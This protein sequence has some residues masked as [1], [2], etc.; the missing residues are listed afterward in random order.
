[1]CESTLYIETKDDREKIADD[2]AL[3]LFDNGEI[4]VRD[5]LGNEKR[6]RGKISEINL[7]KHEIII[8][9]INKN[10]V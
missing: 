3:I 4:I 6:L 9:K 10:G 2:V 1:M 7:I 8:K 5:I